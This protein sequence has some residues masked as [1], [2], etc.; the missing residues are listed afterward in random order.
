MQY[1]PPTTPNN[2]A[3]GPH[4][5]PTTMAS[6]DYELPAMSPNTQS[7]E[8]NFDCKIC[9]NTFR[10]LGEYLKHISKIHFKHKLLEMVPNTS[11]YK[12]PWE[13]CEI[14]KKDRFTIS[15]HYGITHKVALKLMQDMPQEA[16]KEPIE[17]AC[18]LC[19]QKFTAQRYLYSE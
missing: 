6:D 11:P 3:S 17:V 12:C 10:G 18:Q 9:S 2:M 15:L 8:T 16:L 1:F 5:T 19:Q 13:G 14:V 4:Q 7:N